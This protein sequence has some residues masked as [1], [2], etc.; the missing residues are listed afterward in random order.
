MNKIVKKT[1]QNK[2]KTKISFF[3]QLVS[4]SVRSMM[5][6][7]QPKIAS[8]HNIMLIQNQH[9]SIDLEQAQ[10]DYLGI[11]HFLHACKNRPKFCLV[12][13]HLTY[14]D[15]ENVIASSNNPLQNRSN[16]N[17]LFISI[18]HEYWQI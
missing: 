11:S 15:T 4:A 5:H 16:W 18:Y 8:R 6:K 7:S 14:S 3:S 10:I 12:H 13:S 1:R 2:R 9:N 17:G